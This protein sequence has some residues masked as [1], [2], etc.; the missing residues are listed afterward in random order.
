MCAG[1]LGHEPQS[2]I[3][4][5]YIMEYSNFLKGKE[6]ALEKGSVLSMAVLI[7]L[8]NKCGFYLKYEI[9]IIE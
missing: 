5:K 2:S 7:I 8:N 3:G 4:S 6:R 1:T 9:S